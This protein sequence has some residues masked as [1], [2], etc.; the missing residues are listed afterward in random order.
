MKVLILVCII[1]LIGYFFYKRKINTKEV[2][3]T[4]KNKGIL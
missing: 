4:W 2:H 3:K 1:F